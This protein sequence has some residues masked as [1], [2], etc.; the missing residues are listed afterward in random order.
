M[1]LAVI[2]KSRNGAMVVVDGLIGGIE[3][4]AS[5]MLLFL[6]A[7]SLTAI[8]SYFSTIYIG[9]RV[10]SKLSDM[11]YPLLCYSV[12]ALLS[13]IVLLFTGIYGL[14]VFAI[15]TSVGMLA[16]FLKVRKSNAMGVILLPVIL[17]FF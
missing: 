16:P 9:D 13:I 4:D 3:P 10:H 8:L 17:Y 12:I 1:A 14:V 7:V 11:N 6:C 2:G 5:S 15:S